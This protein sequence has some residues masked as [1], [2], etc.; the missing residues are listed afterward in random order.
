MRPGLH[1]VHILHSISKLHVYKVYVLPLLLERSMYS[2][3][4]DV[5]CTPLMKYIA[6]EV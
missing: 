3:W 5:F 6:Y 4:Y 2:C 1:L